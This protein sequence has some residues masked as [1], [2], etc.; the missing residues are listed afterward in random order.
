MHGLRKQKRL[1]YT[2]AWR[3]EVKRRARVDRAARV[4]VKAFRMMGEFLWW[5]SN[6]R[7]RVLQLWWR[8]CLF[9]K[10]CE[11]RI[12]SAIEARR[13]AQI[14]RLAASMMLSS[15]HTCF[16][17]IGFE[18][19]RIAALMGRWEDDRHIKQSMGLG[20]KF[21]VRGRLK[22][23]VV[24]PESG[25]EV[26]ERRYEAFPLQPVESGGPRGTLGSAVGG[27]DANL[28]V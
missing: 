4:I 15:S 1:V 18:R 27:M 23:Q 25:P 5:R 3:V 13:E 22:V 12:R 7:A 16:R 20:P 6:D 8:R 26:I 9:L 19:L 14:K 24:L 10:R 11:R 28:D 17:R 2:I 21:D